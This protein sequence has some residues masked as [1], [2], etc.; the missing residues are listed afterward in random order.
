MTIR[1]TYSMADKFGSLLT[2]RDWHHLKCH[3]V[4][5]YIEINFPIQLLDSTLKVV[6]KV[7]G[8]QA[9]FSH[10]RLGDIRYLLQKL[11]MYKKH[12]QNDGI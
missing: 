2:L 6:T 3:L 10:N 8:E 1:M 5:K 11:Q 4:V 9:R 7:K 12:S